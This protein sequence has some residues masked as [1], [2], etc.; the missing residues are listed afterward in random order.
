MFFVVKYHIPDLSLNIC[1][2]IF[3]KKNLIC[4]V[5]FWLLFSIAG[6][7]HLKVKILITVEVYG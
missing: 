1:L 6:W 3:L 2:E 5:C 4:T 7:E